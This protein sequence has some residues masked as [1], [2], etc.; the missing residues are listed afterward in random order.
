MNVAVSLDAELD[1]AVVKKV[2]EI[3]VPDVAALYNCE[4]TQDVTQQEEDEL[5]RVERKTMFYV[6][7]V[8]KK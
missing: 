7:C 1:D 4:T 6:R 8:S 5:V 3:V 2:P